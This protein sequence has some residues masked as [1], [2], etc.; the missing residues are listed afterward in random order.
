[1]KETPRMLKVGFFLSKLG[2]R[3]LL[4]GRQGVADTTLIIG[5]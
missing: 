1:M 3:L 5:N 4:P 2:A